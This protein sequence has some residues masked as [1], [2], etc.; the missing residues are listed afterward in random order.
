GL[1]QAVPIL[2]RL[3][4]DADTQVR[5]A[6]IWALGQIDGPESERVLT[7]AYDEADEEMAAALDEALAEH[8]LQEGELDLPLYEVDDDMA[9]AGLDGGE[10]LW[11]D[12]DDDEDI[13]DD[14]DDD[15]EAEEDELIDD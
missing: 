1:R 8:A 15:A 13:E 9:A 4:E 6:S 2:A 10:P 14:E 5:E 3:I 11:D 7:D 12:V